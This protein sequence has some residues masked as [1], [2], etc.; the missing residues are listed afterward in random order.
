LVAPSLAMVFPKAFLYS[1]APKVQVSIG[2]IH[3]WHIISLPV[4]SL[5]ISRVPGSV[6]L[7]QASSNCSSRVG[8]LET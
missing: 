2:K 8:I 7:A 3:H 4:L 1:N 6:E 5:A